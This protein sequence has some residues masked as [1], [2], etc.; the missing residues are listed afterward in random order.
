MNMTL[1]QKL[2]AKAQTNKI[3]F[4][5]E[6]NVIF[7]NCECVLK[8]VCGDICEL[9]ERYSNSI[10]TCKID[11]LEIDLLALNLI[12]NDIHADK[13]GL[14]YKSAEYARLDNLEGKIYSLAT[15]ALIKMGFSL[16]QSQAIEGKAYEDGH[17]G[18]CAEVLC[19]VID[20]A[21]F[22]KSILKG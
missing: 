1:K 3:S 5:R 8:S 10:G 11:N 22:A 21:E 9:K 4:Q 6:I 20:Y 2:E 7:N 14:D 12:L 16:S 15:K 13:F 19:K 18:G 17:S